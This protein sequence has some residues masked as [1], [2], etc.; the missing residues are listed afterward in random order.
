[1]QIID[2]PLPGCFLLKPQVI[3]D[4]RGYFFESFNMRVFSAATGISQSFLQDNQSY[5]GY[6]VIR[7]LHAQSG[8]HAQSKLVRVIQGEVLDVA[9]DLRKDS[10]THGRWFSAVLSAENKHQLY[11]PRG[12]AHG[13]A[14][15]SPFAEFLYK[16]DAYYNK[17]SEFGVYYAD[18]DLNIDWKIPESERIL[19]PKDQVLPAFK[20]V[21]SDKKALE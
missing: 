7:G 5:S 1:M 3:E 15:L 14:V 11:I 19:S 18:P 2:E 10:P 13:F 4:Q 6:G 20:E 8:I 9:L 16:C 17:A 21:I 12:F